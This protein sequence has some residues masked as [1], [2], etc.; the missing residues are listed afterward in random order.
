MNEIYG[1]EFMTKSL[2]FIWEPYYGVDTDSHGKVLKE[3]A[4]LVDAGKIRSY[5]RKSLRLD[6]NGL[7][8]EHQ[9]IEGERIMGK[10]GLGVNVEIKGGNPPFT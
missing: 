1:T 2:T 3:L 7:R 4:E 9:T 5:L 6:L 8:K 10:V